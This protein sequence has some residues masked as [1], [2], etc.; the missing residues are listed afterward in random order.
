MVTRQPKKTKTDEEASDGNDEDEIACKCDNFE[1]YATD[2]NGDNHSIHYV[3]ATAVRRLAANT[4][5]V[6]ILGTTAK[7]KSLGDSPTAHQPL[8]ERQKTW[9]SAADA[10]LPKPSQLVVETR[11]VEATAVRTLAAET[12]SI[13][14]LGTTADPKPQQENKIAKEEETGSV[15]FV[16]ATAVRHLAAETG[17]IAI[18]ASTAA[19]AASP[20]Q[21]S[22]DDRDDLELMPVGVRE[23]L[24]S[25]PIEVHGQKR[26]IVPDDKQENGGEQ[27]KNAWTLDC[28]PQI[29]LP[30]VYALGM[31]SGTRGFDD[32]FKTQSFASSSEKRGLPPR[33]I[34]TDGVNPGGG[35]AFEAF[36][37]KPLVRQSNEACEQDENDYLTLIDGWIPTIPVFAKC[38][39][40][41]AKSKY[42]TINES[43]LLNYSVWT[44]CTIFIIILT[45]LT[46]DSF[47]SSR[48]NML[49]AQNNQPLKK[50]SNS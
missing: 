29:P 32:T 19:A 1:K 10:D 12:G 21:R 20:L 14:I 47:S 26:E 25:E 6:A 31:K 46:G 48:R 33:S 40:A 18:L 3:E 49:D 35:S 37:R 38:P 39:P 28:D 22:E 27:D 8:S 41:K 36:S 16:E 17:T 24:D 42:Q 9:P 4:S 15:H 34:T 45:I 2:E 13:A 5:S 50:I 7:C 43:L 30:V 23:V 44:V 11:Y